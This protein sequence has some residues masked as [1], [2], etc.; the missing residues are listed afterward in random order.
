[1]DKVL[2]VVDMQEMYVGRVEIK[3][4]THMMPNLLS[5]P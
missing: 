2:F 4:H 1:M 5:T 3:P